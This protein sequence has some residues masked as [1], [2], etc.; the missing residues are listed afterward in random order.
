MNSRMIAIVGGCVGLVLAILMCVVIFNSG[1]APTTTPASPSPTSQPTGPTGPFGQLAKSLNE[2]R[3]LEESLEKKTLSAPSP[4]PPAGAPAAPLA[5]DESAS[6]QEDGTTSE[7]AP[8]P[9]QKPGAPNPQ[10]APKRVTRPEKWDQDLPKRPLPPG[11][12]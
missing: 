10:D 12:E 9:Q 6:P 4:A 1:P 7:Q 5:P 11:I 8:P 2:Q 3:A